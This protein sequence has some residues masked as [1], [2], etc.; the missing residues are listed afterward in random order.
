M[1]LPKVFAEATGAATGPVARGSGR[2]SGKVWVDVL[3]TVSLFEGVSDRHL[4]KIAGLGTVTTYERG[5]AVVRKGEPGDACYIVLEG[6]AEVVTGRGRAGIPLQPGAVFG[7]M[8][9]LDDAP[10][11]ASVVADT[12]LVLF[13]LGRAQFTK[14]LRAEPAVALALLKTL[15]GRLRALTGS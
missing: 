14:M 9:L 7:E 12:E 5:S 2:T 8:A 6:R 13:R 3:R 1:G 10:R 15:A 11:S 4:R